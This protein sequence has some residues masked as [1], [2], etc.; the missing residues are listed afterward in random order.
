MKQAFAEWRA[1][2]RI[3][4]EETPLVY[5]V[6]QIL[7]LVATTNQSTLP[8]SVNDLSHLAK[9]DDGSLCSIRHRNWLSERLG[10][11]GAVNNS[12]AADALRIAVISQVRA[13]AVG[14]LTALG[15][16]TGGPAGAVIGAV[17]GALIQ[18]G[19]GAL[20]SNTWCKLQCDD[21]G[22]ANGVTALFNGCTFTGIMATGNA[23]EFNEGVTFRIDVNND[24]QTDFTVPSNP[25]STISRSTLLPD[26]R[27][28]RVQADVTCD[29]DEEIDWG[30][31][32][33]WIP[34]DPVRTGPT[35]NPTAN[36]T[37]PPMSG[38]S[39]P[40]GQPLAFSANINTNGWTYLGW[41]SP[42][43]SPS[44]GSGRT[45]TVRY[46]VVGIVEREITF[47]F[48]NPCTGATLT[49]SGG[50]PFLICDADATGGY[51]P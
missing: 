22:A 28:F 23:F 51:C 48:R 8:V 34:I 26:D 7:E 15:F 29:G 18:E 24:R 27:P 13:G 3:N 45:F 19:L 14:G 47:R 40:A 2:A 9:S 46:N 25:G 37:L 16:I 31:P 33:N 50:E 32:T 17:V 49:L 10:L 20:W 11:C 38:M 39:Y 6:S 1:D 4:Q 30:N 44:S 42:G 41:S 12:V 21:C 35:L 43:G 5:H 36:L